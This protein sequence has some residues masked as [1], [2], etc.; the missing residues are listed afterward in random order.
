MTPP[1]PAPFHL[2]VS[3]KDTSKPLPPKSQCFAVSPS[4]CNQPLNHSLANSPVALVSFLRLCGRAS[5]PRPPDR[6]SC[7]R[8]LLIPTG[9]VCEGRDTEESFT[10]CAHVC[11]GIR[12]PPDKA[13]APHSDVL[14]LH[15]SQL[16]YLSILFSDRFPCTS[17]MLKYVC[18]TAHSHPEQPRSVGTTATRAVRIIFIDG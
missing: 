5:P 6:P 17:E 18:V 16:A 10:H 11:L 3:G 9:A 14:C 4:T 8:P 13:P 2:G 1:L 15:M 7:L 12:R